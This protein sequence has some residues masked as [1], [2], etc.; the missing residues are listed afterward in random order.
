MAQVII[1]R[2]GSSVRSSMSRFH[3]IWMCEMCEV[4]DRRASQGA[5][6]SSLSSPSVGSEIGPA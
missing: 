5:W 2:P 1:E 4:S 6:G 3:T